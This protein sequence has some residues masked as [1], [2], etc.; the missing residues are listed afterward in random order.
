MDDGFYFEKVRG[1]FY[2]M[3]EKRSIL[4]VHPADPTAEICQRRGML[5]GRGLLRESYIEIPFDKSSVHRISLNFCFAGIWVAFT[6]LAFRHVVRLFNDLL[7][8]GGTCGLAQWRCG[9]G[10]V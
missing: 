7:F 3:E 4:A 10:F 8:S 5:S 6:S 9:L 1:V 2:K